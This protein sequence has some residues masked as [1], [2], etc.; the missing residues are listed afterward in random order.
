LFLNN[1]LEIKVCVDEKCLYKF[2][3]HHEPIT[4]EQV[5]SL[6]NFNGDHKHSCSIE[7]K[8]INNGESALDFDVV[9]RDV[10][11]DVVLFDGIS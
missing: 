4:K 8:L 3:S 5:G 6:C 11:K 2:M 10:A 7:V 9:L 1:L